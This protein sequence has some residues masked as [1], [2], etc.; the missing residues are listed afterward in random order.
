MGFAP[1]LSMVT[2]EWFH[3][4]DVAAVATDT[5][6]LEVLPCEDK[7]IYLPV[8]LLHIVEMGM[9]QGQNWLLDPLAADCAEDGVYTF[10]LDATPAAADQRPRLSGQ[11][12]GH[13]VTRNHRFVRCTK[14][15]D[16]AVHFCDER[17]FSSSLVIFCVEQ[18]QC[19]W[20]L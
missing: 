8:H 10:L 2:A 5:L 12:G 14:V 4:R 1:G 11:S 9:T 15:H 18:A 7:D 19:E 13:Q 3:A 16:H 20:E 17:L 6:S